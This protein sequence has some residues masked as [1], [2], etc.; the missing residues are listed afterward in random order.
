MND[1]IV[2]VAIKIDAVDWR[3]GPEKVQRALTLA[4]IGGAFLP[5]CAMRIDAQ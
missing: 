3:P 4:G 2:Q 1:G 5:R